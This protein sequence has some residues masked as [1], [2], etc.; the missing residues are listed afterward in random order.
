MGVFCHVQGVDL[1]GVGGVA[2][3][4]VCDDVGA[5]AAVDG[6][7]GGGAVGVRVPGGHSAAD[8]IGGRD[9]AVQKASDAQKFPREERRNSSQS[10][11][12]SAALFGHHICFGRHR[13]SQ[14]HLH[15]RAR[16][17][18]PR[19]QLHQAPRP[20]E[21]CGEGLRR[22]ALGR[23]RRGRRPHAA[24]APGDRGGPDG[25]R[26]HLPRH[27]PRVQLLQV[28]GA[29]SAEHGAR[30]RAGG[31]EAQADPAAGTVAGDPG[32]HLAGDVLL[33]PLDDLQLAV[34][35]FQE[36]RAACRVDAVC[37]V[38]DVLHACG[39]GVQHTEP[40]PAPG[41]PRANSET[42]A[43]VEVVDE[44]ERIHLLHYLDLADRVWVF[45]VHRLRYC[46][47]HGLG[48]PNRYVAV[49]EVS[50]WPHQEVHQPAQ[51]ADPDSFL[52]VQDHVHQSGRDGHYH[53]RDGFRARM[54][55]MYARV[56]PDLRRGGR[57]AH[58]GPRPV[59]R[60]RGQSA[61]AGERQDRP[62][63]G[64]AQLPAV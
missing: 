54:A 24:Q 23:L 36:Q 29:G 62:R 64:A 22:P 45:V 5:G 7:G 15:L 28:H 10:L 12:H 35:D 49:H 13:N 52:G 56:G 31:V 43:L 21:A 46:W 2:V 57:R 33:P 40:N 30:V 8:E 20:A 51:S 53:Q 38:P 60:R 42:W 47:G 9:H 37:V 16:S 50:S 14:R 27:V 32:H 48:R 11:R 19:Q 63:A 58:R 26:G 61:G 18:G 4:S 39:G 17:R 55:P 25:L 34:A 6:A 44:A 1:R 41:A 59:P 3:R